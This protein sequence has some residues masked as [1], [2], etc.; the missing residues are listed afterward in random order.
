MNTTSVFHELFSGNINPLINGFNTL[1]FVAGIFL[2]FRAFLFLGRNRR[3]MK[4]FDKLSRNPGFSEEDIREV[5]ES[6]TYA[7]KG[8]LKRS[9]TL[10]SELSKTSLADRDKI[11][12][13]EDILN[14]IRTAVPRAIPNLAVIIGFLGTV[15]GL[16][17]AIRT[18][19]EIFQSRCIKQ[20]HG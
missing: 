11:M 14:Q 7:D 3:E 10:L 12:Y 20:H 19:P 2:L 5:M 18:M 9:M 17:L 16:F 13:L 6:K 8:I 15:L 1:L 4:K